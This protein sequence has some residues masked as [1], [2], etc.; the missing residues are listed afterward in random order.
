[1][2]EI[3]Y[4]PDPAA[5]RRRIV[6]LEEERDRLR[7]KLAAASG[8]TGV[9]PA[10]RDHAHARHKAQVMEDGEVVAQAGD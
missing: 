9:S 6:E 3:D 10:D 2:T 1:M 5:M 8:G 7:A 4:G